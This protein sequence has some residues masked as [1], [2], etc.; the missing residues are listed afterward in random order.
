MKAND[1]NNYDMRKHAQVTTANVEMFLVETG[2]SYMYTEIRL[3]LRVL[4]FDFHSYF[5]W[6]EYY[7]RRAEPAIGTGSSHYK[8]SWLGGYS[9]GG[10]YHCL[11]ACGPMFSETYALPL[12][13]LVVDSSHTTT[14]KVW[15]KLNTC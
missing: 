5:Y 9:G 11:I 6:P 15:K 12:S 1:T 7:M 2:Y 14:E 4:M 3:Q 13:Q 10:V 8:G